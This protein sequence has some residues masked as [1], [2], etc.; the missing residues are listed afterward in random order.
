MQTTI[1]DVKFDEKFKSE[2][3]I[4]LP[5]KENRKIAKICRK[6][7]ENSEKPW[8]S[9]YHLIRKIHGILKVLRAQSTCN[10]LSFLEIRA[11]LKWCFLV[12]NFSIKSAFLHFSGFYSLCRPIPPAG[13]DSAANFT[14][15]IYFLVF[16]FYQIRL[17]VWKIS[18]NDD[19]VYYAT[20]RKL[21]MRFP[22][23]CLSLQP[24]RM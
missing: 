23:E 18:K 4:R 11:N 24:E 1:I 9:V 3:R 19:I 16:F 15:K 17:L 14:S 21:S 22:I 6:T 2:L 8:K 5:C 12:M 13:F 7:R 20:Q 10:W